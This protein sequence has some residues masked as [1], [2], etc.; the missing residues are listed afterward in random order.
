MNLRQWSLLIAGCIGT[1]AV[2][3]SDTNTL[4]IA[5]TQHNLTFRAGWERELPPAGLR[6]TYDRFGPPSE[7][8]WITA[9]NLQRY[10]IHEFIATHGRDATL[11]IMESA[12]RESA[13]E[14]LPLAE[15]E[16]DG[17][18]LWSIFAHFVRGSIGNTAEEEVSV[19]SATSSYE[20]LRHIAEFEPRNHHEKLW[21]YNYGLRPLSK[22]PY[23]YYNANIGHFA[24]RQLLHTGTRLYWHLFDNV[25][26]VKVESQV[27][28][29]LGKQAQFVIG[30]AIYP[31]DMGSIKHQSSASARWETVIGEGLGSIGMTTTPTEN[32]YSVSW[33]RSF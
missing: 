18:Y 4:Y 23:F 11:K 10:G 24:G 29:T 6:I 25:S 27:V 16:N 26:L 13:V 17:R 5:T 28:V 9:Y 21:N 30:G 12:A 1:E 32:F 14:T 31:T 22:K 7:F 2:L 15:Y 20:T 33:S 3:A 8:G 19:V